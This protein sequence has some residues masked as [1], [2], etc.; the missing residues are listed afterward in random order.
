[1]GK[2]IDKALRTGMQTGADTASHVAALNDFGLK[3]VRLLYQRTRG[4]NVFISPVS[5]G[6]SL[7][8][9]LNGAGGKTKRSISKLLKTRSTTHDD[10]NRASQSLRTH[11][12]GVCGA[13]LAFANGLWADKSVLFNPLFVQIIA[14]YYDASANTLDFGA[15]AA[16]EIINE[17]TRAH[18][19]G[20]IDSVIESSDLG[21]QTSCVVVNA[22]YFK[23]DWA[24]PFD[25]GATTEGLFHLQN[26]RKKAVQLMSQVNAY[27]YSETATTQLISLSY[28]GDEISA[29]F[30]LPG[31]NMSLKK[32]LADLDAKKWNQ[33]LAGL[34]EQRVE[35]MLP[36]F[37]LSYEADLCEPLQKIGLGVT[38][39]EAAD[40]GPMG[41][42]G[43]FIT[44]FKHKTMAE[45]NE[46][47]TE[48]AATTM[49]IMG[50]SLFTPRR[51]IINR[52]FFC[53]IRDNTSGVLLF[54]G[55]VSDPS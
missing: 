7:A 51:M 14:D 18:T 32:L 34:K 44:Q 31:P 21:S 10:F 45:V 25:I 12:E 53:A 17:W 48:A 54:V 11:L 46:E 4:E 37:Q 8:I 27:L 43:H 13:Q 33:L 1:M 49:V 39:N 28:S 20:K 41:L 30:L 5:I 35:L 50:R 2:K 38:C 6:F 26:K 23:G 47:G 15:G 40:F 16:V 29:Y 52:P 22:A 3:L 36:R 19:L 55:A 24:A 42:P 9:L